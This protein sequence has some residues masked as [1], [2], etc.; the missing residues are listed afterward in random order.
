MIKRFLLIAILA[1]ST[2]LG[3]A[4]ESSSVT[5]TIPYTQVITLYLD[6]AVEIPL[7]TYSGLRSVTFVNS[8]VDN[9]SRIKRL[10]K[11]IPAHTGVLVKGNRGT[12]EFPIVSGDLTENPDYERDLKLLAENENLLHGCTEETLISANPDL[13]AAQKAGTLWTLQNQ[14][15]LLF[16]RFTGESLA[17]NKCYIL[18]DAGSAVKELEMSIDEEATAIVNLAEEQGESS[19]WYN[20][21]GIRLTGHPSRKGIYI[22]N[23]KL[24]SIK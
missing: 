23:G 7:S 18:Y 11:V 22:Q 10:D 13:L 8:I 21:Q 5:V 2:H 3:W 9:S 15:R 12:Y 14:P 19:V 1:C 6:V 20:L 17:A 24:V 4:Q 16:K